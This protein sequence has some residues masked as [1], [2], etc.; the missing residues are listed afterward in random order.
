M[1]L[2][3][4]GWYFH[5]PDATIRWWDGS[6][7]TPYVLPGQPSQLVPQPAA[8]AAYPFASPGTSQ[9]FRRPGFLQSGWFIVVSGLVLLI[10]GYLLFGSG[11]L[12]Q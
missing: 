5:E 1:E 7:W 4:A 12:A 2:P 3:Q 6:S 9:A 8:P 10:L 11:F